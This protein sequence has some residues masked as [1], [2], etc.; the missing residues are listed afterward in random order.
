[1]SNNIFVIAEHLKG[2]TDDITYEMLGKARALAG[3]TGGSV[4]AVL[5]GSGASGLAADYAADKVLY[6]D[7]ANL[8]EFNPE[9]YGR[10]LAEI[11]NSQSPQI[12]LVGNSSQ[13]MDIGAALSVDCNM[14]IVAYASDMSADTVTS[15]LYGGKMSVESGVD[16]DRY[17]ASVL[18]GSFS[19]DTG[20]QWPDPFGRGMGYRNRLSATGC[21]ATTIRITRSLTRDQ[22]VAATANAPQAGGRR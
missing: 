10:A 8:A 19:A 6:V 2:K 9:A 1:M 11:I 16:G 21:V 20:K 3:S 7:H 17:I 22:P 4:V 13:G 15:Q 5:L 12:V 18:P 14:P